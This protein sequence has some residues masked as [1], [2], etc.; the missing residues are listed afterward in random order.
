M[1]ND[2]Q[3]I[4]EEK[5]DCEGFLSDKDFWSADVAENLARANEIGEYQLSDAHWKVINFVRS[6]YETNGRGPEIVKVAKNT[7]LTMKDIC[8]LF[9]CGLVKGAYRLAGLPRPPGCV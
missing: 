7:N 1:E 9:P 5:L 6:Y 4:M 2:N 8:R 3:N